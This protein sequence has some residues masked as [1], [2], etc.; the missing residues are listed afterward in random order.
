M[1]HQP[2]GFVHYQHIV[3][4]I[5]DVERDILGYDFKFIPRPVHHHGDHIVGLHTVVRL[6]RFS[7]GQN[8]A[9]VGSLLYAV[10]RCFLH[11]VHQKLIDTEQ[12][13][14]LVGHKAE[15]LIHAI[16]IGLA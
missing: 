8:A 9:G 4:L 11:M 12:L 1:H 6:H 16:G 2:G 7:V 10:A 3:V 13:L 15:M 14:A 5:H